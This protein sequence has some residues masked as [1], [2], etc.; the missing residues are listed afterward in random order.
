[1]SKST[2]RRPVTEGDAVALAGQQTGDQAARRSGSDNGDAQA[3]GCEQGGVPVIGVL[4]GDE[5]DAV[6]DLAHLLHVVAHVAG[7]A[8]AVRK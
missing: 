8:G 1:M 4:V 3:H 5:A 7:G 2:P 6:D